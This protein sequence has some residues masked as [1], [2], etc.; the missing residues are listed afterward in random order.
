MSRR[1][2]ALLPAAIVA[3]G[4]EVLVALGHVVG[5]GGAERL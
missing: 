3:V 2:L 4:I 1:P 5:D